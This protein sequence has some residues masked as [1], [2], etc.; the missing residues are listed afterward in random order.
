[1]S[2]CPCAASAYSALTWTGFSGDLTHL[3]CIPSWSIPDE[4]T[5]LLIQC[6]PEHEW[7]YFMYI[8]PLFC[9]GNNTMHG[10]HVVKYISFCGLNWSILDTNKY[11]ENSSKTGSKPSKGSWIYLRS[12]LSFLYYLVSKGRQL[13][14]I[15]LPLNFNSS[16]LHT[17]FK[18]LLYLWRVLIIF[19]SARGEE[20]KFFFNKGIL[21]DI[22]KLFL[23]S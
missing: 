12:W 2:Q 7:S 20:N 1:M 19:F 18:R 22:T 3:V 23:A 4:S 13:A 9:R 15:Y 8:V 6:S 21:P 11:N 17:H 16:N 10:L 14:S 5:V